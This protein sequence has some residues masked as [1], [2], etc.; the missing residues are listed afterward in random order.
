MRSTNTSG[1]GTLLRMLWHRV[2][3]ADRL[4]CE[5]TAR[6]EARVRRKD[7]GQRPKPSEPDRLRKGH[8]A[9]R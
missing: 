5:R 7:R 2:A 6:R 1:N 8:K 4:V 3:L 9:N